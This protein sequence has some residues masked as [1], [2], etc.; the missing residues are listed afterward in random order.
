M[1]TQVID[2]SIIAIC[3]SNL[4]VH[5]LLVYTRSDGE[6]DAME[7]KPYRQKLIASSCPFHFHCRSILKLF[8]PSKV[9][10]V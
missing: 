6:A 10:I 4:R 8:I 3:G 5:A 2:N 7:M 9:Y 1:F